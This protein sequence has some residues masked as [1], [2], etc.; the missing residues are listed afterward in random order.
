[1]KLLGLK[2]NHKS[3]HLFS[4]TA[5][6]MLSSGNGMRDGFVRALVFLLSKQDKKNAALFHQKKKMKPRAIAES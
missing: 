1:M 5:Q 3:P 6:H 2:M 4:D